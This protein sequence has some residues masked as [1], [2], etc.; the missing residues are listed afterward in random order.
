VAA[1][2]HEEIRRRI[3]E[4]IEQQFLGGSDVSELTDDTPLLEWSVLTSMNTSLL[5][6]FIRTGLGVVV[7]PTHITGRNFAT[8][9]AI[10]DMVHGL[11]RQPAA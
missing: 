10:T 1:L 2:S 5:L 6:S 3:S 4:Y 7:P 11:T 8:V 9:T